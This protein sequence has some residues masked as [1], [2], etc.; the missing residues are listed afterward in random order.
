MRSVARTGIDSKRN[1]MERKKVKIHKKS[2]GIFL[3]VFTIEFN[4]VKKKI[5]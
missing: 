4:L 3:A 1:K 2:K 5:F